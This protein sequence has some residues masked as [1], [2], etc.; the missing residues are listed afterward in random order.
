MPETSDH[1]PVRSLMHTITVGEKA[2]DLVFTDYS[3]K[4]MLVLTHLKSL[5]TILCIRQDSTFE[6]HTTY[7]ITTL[8]GKRD[9]VVLTLCARRIAELA[10][11]AGNTKPI[12]LCLGIQPF[13]KE[14]IKDI[15]AAVEAC[16]LWG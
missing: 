7:N 13:E 11:S 9:D 12:V 1:F 8:L 2:V 16:H 6:G 5:G 4:C 10:H 14:L 15:C 3:D